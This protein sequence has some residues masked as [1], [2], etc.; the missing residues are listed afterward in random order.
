MDIS[1]IPLN[2]VSWGV[3]SVC[4]MVFALKSFYRHRKLQIAVSYYFGWFGLLVSIAMA[5]YSFPA[6]FSQNIDLLRTFYTAGDGVLYLALLVQARMLWFLAL[7]SQIAFLLIG[8]PVAIVGG[9]SWLIE[10]RGAALSIQ[11]NFMYFVTPRL[12]SLLQ[13]WLLL[14]LLLPTGYYFIR[15]GLNQIEP[16]AKAKSIAV[17]LAYLIVGANSSFNNF[18][19]SGLESPS[20]SIQNIVIFLVLLVATLWPSAKKS[21]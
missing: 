15:E 13:G 2:A 7:R 11:D 21:I 16:K 9:V 1:L 10:A 20:T 14:A 12:S 19:N 8:V 17:G 6:F 3:G 4:V 5:G 18:A